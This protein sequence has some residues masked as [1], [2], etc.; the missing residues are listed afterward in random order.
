MTATW[1]ALG[2]LGIATKDAEGKTLTFDQ[3]TANMAQTFK[4]QAS[5]A[6]GTLEG[7]MGRLSLI[8]SETKETI[9]AA[10]LPALTNVGTWFLEKG[11]PDRKSVV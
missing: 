11:V 9:G 1:G 4:G 5:D 8:F 7:K 6:A 10:F 2:R 3:I